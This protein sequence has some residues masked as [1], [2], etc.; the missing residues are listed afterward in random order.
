MRPTHLCVYTVQRLRPVHTSQMSPWAG[1]MLMA[2][3]RFAGQ[4][5]CPHVSSP[6]LPTPQAARFALAAS[7]L[8]QTGR[9]EG[10]EKDGVAQRSGAPSQVDLLLRASAKNRVI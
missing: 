4:A 1:S 5:K 6:L 2:A 10:L 8:E 9:G 3:S 7:P